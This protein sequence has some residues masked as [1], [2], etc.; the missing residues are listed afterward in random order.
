MK[1]IE[2]MKLLIAVI[3][4]ALKIIEQSKKKD[5]LDLGDSR[6]L[7]DVARRLQ[8]ALDYSQSSYDLLAEVDD[9]FYQKSGHYQSKDNDDQVIPL[10]TFV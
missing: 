8:E 4:A 7:D 3:S 6:L 2:I 5:K 1:C 9:H 10:E